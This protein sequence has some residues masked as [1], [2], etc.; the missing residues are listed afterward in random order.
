MTTHRAALAVSHDTSVVTSP[1]TSRAAM[2]DD[3]HPAVTNFRTYLQINTAQPCP[4][5][6]EYRQNLSL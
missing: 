2:A 4:D 1:V 3:E 5:Y 6:G